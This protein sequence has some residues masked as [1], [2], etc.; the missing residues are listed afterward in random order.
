[1]LFVF[2]SARRRRTIGVFYISKTKFPLPDRI[3]DLMNR[4]MLDIPNIKSNHHPVHYAALLHKELVSIHPFIDG[5][6]RISR[7]VMNLTLIKEGYPVIIIPPILRSG[8]LDCLRLS[9]TGNATPFLNFISHIVYD[10]QK[11]YLRLL[12]S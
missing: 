12:D 3:P 9:D 5:N 11:D 10:S 6:G 1:M 2:I 4:L 8:Y 7:L